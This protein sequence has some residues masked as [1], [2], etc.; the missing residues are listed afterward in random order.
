MFLLLVATAATWHLCLTLSVNVGLKLRISNWI[1]CSNGGALFAYPCC[2]L[3]SDHN[4]PEFLI[5]IKIM[6][7]VTRELLSDKYL[8]CLENYILTTGLWHSHSNCRIRNGLYTL[9]T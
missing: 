1:K 4:D 9:F 6:F 5:F 2:S 7:D 3:L 8:V